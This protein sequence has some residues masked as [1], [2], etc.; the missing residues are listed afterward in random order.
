MLVRPGVIAGLQRMQQLREAL[1]ELITAESWAERPMTFL[2][3]WLNDGAHARA[4][5][6]D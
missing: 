4:R 6:H 3:L 5:T 1:I 2:N